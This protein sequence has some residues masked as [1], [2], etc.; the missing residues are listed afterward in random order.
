MNHTNFIWIFFTLFALSND[1]MGSTKINSVP[2]PHFSD[3]ETAEIIDSPKKINKEEENDW[4]DTLMNNQPKAIQ[5][6]NNQ[7]KKSKKKSNK[8]YISDDEFEII[9]DPEEKLDPKKKLKILRETIEKK[10]K[11]IAIKN[12][13]IE[14]NKKNLEELEKQLEKKGIIIQK[15]SDIIDNRVA[16]TLGVLKKGMVFPENESK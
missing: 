14:E 1:A 13:K 16:E 5:N 9:I 4:D 3:D 12:K 8:Y 6:I 11:E 7:I 2:T 15:L 10:D